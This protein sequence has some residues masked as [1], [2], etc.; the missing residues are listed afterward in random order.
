MHMGNSWVANSSSREGHFVGNALHE[1]RHRSCC[2]WSPVLLILAVALV[3]SARV[4]SQTASTGAL[5]G[6]VLDP[7]G[8]VLTGVVVRLANQDTG[9]IRSATSD[10]DGRFNFLL[11]RVRFLSKPA[12]QVATA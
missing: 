9:T 12:P 1:Y 3:F 11:L 10:E 8:A 2:R 4:R 6:V 7:T 5:S